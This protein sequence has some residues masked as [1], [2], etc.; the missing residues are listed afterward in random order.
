MNAWICDSC[1]AVI[2]QEEK[3]KNC[4]LCNRKSNFTSHEINETKDEISQKYDEALKKLEEYEEGVPKRK[5]TDLSCNCP[6]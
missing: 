3:P 6:K 2:K 1:G 4:K 5:L